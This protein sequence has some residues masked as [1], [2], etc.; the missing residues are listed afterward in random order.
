MWDN[1]AAL[2]RTSD[3]LIAIAGLIVLYSVIRFAIV[4]PVFA[5]REIRVGGSTSQVTLQQV[6]AIA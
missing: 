3:L 4:Q 5:M 1:A 2:N 6:E